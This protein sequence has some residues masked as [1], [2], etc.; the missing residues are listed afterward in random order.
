MY[1][2][3]ISVIALLMV[4]GLWANEN[5]GFILGAWVMLSAACGSAVA[6]RI[7]CGTP[8]VRCLL[9]GGALLLAMFAVGYLCW[10]GMV[11]SRVNVALVL[12]ALLGSLLPGFFAGRKRRK[13]AW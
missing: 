11:W 2:L 1:L 6:L 8:I 4:K 5:A 9:Q 13:R 3:G 12:C 7:K 10:E